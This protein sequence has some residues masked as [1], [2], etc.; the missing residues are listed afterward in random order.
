[1]TKQWSL[2]NLTIQSK[3]LLMTG[4]VTFIALLLASGIQILYERHAF[5]QHTV[6]EIGVLAKAIANRS[7]AAILFN[8]HK[9]ASENL[10]ALSLH[11]NIDHACLYRSDGSLFAKYTRGNHAVC[12]P[13]PLATGF[14]FHQH[15][16]ELTQLVTIEDKHLGSIHVHANLEALTAATINHIS[17]T[18]LAMLAAII[19][20]FISAKWMQGLISKP[21][22]HLA[23][24]ARQVTET[25]D[26]DIRAEKHAKDEIGQL[27]D[28]FNTML[29]TIRAGNISLRESRERFQALTESTSDWI[30]E[31]DAQ[32]TYTYASPRV[33]AL[34]GYTPEEII[35]KTPFHL[36]LPGEARQVEKKFAAFA[37]AGQPFEGIENSNIHKDGRYIILESSGVPIFTETGQLRGY[38]GIDRDM[39]ERKYLAKELD[40]HR[41]HLEE[42][43]R[44]RTTQLAEQRARAEAA[45]HAKS[46]FLANMSH[47]LRT[48]LNAI[49]GFS[50]LMQQ[51][52]ELPDFAQKNLKII[53]SS[54]QHLLTL[55]NDILDMSKIE[56][57]KMKL[58][59]E[60]FSLVAMT[61]DITD[62][63]RHRAQEKGLELNIEQDASVPQ[64]ICGDASKLR[65]IFINLLS[66]AVKFTA[67]G[68]VSLRLSVSDRNPVEK[69]QTATSLQI[70]HVEV[71]DTGSGI[72]EHDLPH[73]F[74]PFEQ[75]ASS[76][77]Q[78]GTGLGLT[79][80]KQ[81]VE[82]M[83]GNINVN[84]TP[85]QGSLF[86][87]E[88]PVTP[89][90]VVKPSEFTTPG[91][92]IGLKPGQA[93]YRILIVED[94][95]EN[96]LLLKTLL[97][98][99]G[100][101]TS[102]A[103]DGHQAIAQFKSWHPHFIWMDQCLPGM[104][105]KEITR[106]IREL[107]D[108]K[109]VKIAAITASAFE[110][111]REQILASGMDDY[112]RKPFHSSEIFDCLHRL[113]DIEFIYEQTQAREPRVVAERLS[114][115]HFKQLPEPLFNTLHQAVL[116]LD[117]EKC[118]DAIKQI[119]DIDLMLADLLKYYCEKYE[120][121]AILEP[122]EEKR[123]PD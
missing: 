28:S 52:H 21:I 13:A 46:M 115:A 93:E 82:M 105:G 112:I 108:G 16:L 117:M 75:L 71:E 88:L 121:Q 26:Y 55:I 102:E 39:T 95:A 106:H 91:T 76:L 73:L 120:F 33:E 77:E 123:F 37:Q 43:V 107:P 90:S 59:Q 89:V 53:N 47:E 87:I 58:E 60:T 100:L 97:E 92:V 1:M 4:I 114:V 36:M 49:L 34:L 48:P 20:A 122:L 66:N 41:H 54:G 2:L 83:G 45:N 79:I 94:Q 30:W 5:K 23:A 81:F 25:R 64:N 68:K 9:V 42:L 99:A 38:R 65:Q 35:G 70:L 103:I 104:D 8:D 7:T 15:V 96:R 31:V 111:E 44:E 118:N 57:G 51:N 12:P 98:Q 27:V 72:A 29:A 74:Q 67:M 14:K 63:M 101:K 80:T 78:K 40:K 110:E 18:V 69:T 17:V 109:S 86:V 56:A 50:E 3:L 116:M 85:G 119:A 10:A 24:V 32:G 11:T 22:A 84:S 6:E 113:L 19:L 61:E 62:M